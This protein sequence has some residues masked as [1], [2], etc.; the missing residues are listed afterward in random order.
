MTKIAIN[1]VN[2]M[3]VMIASVASLNWSLSEISD[4]MGHAAG[5]IISKKMNIFLMA[6]L[7][8]WVRLLWGI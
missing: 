2:M 1:A 3:I 8:C 5:K 4:M 6:P 7:L